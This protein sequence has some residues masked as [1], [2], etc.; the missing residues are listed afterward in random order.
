M[1]IAV[2]ILVIALL[3]STLLVV[4]T[5]ASAQLPSGGAAADRWAIAYSLGRFYFNDPPKPDQIFKIQYKITDG[6]VDI[7]TSQSTGSF[8]IYID[9]NRDG[10]VEVKYPRTFPY[11]DAVSI[12]EGI[13]GRDAIVFVNEIEEFHEMEVTDCFYEFSI[14]FSGDTKIDVVWPFL[15][16]MFPHHGDD[17]PARCIEETVVANVPTRADGIIAPLQQFKVGIDVQD[18]VCPA[19]FTLLISPFERPYCATSASAEILN[20]RWNSR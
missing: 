15:G 14:P 5:P 18:I 19:G 11:S 13:D 10:L 4:L 9:S 7:A 20:E 8:T 16:A 2:T 12:V 1:A 6:T 17:V 3:L